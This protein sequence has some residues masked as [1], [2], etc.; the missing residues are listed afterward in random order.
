MNSIFIYRV[1]NSAV[2]A[3]SRETAKQLKSPFVFTPEIMVG[4]SAP[5][6][7]NFP[8]RDPQTQLILN[9]GWLQV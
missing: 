9:F 2:F 4:Y 8:D 1:W 6:N 7:E 3:A 5:S